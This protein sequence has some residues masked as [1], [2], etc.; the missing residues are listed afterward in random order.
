MKITAFSGL[1]IALACS[2]ASAA[3]WLVVASGRDDVLLVDRASLAR[4]GTRAEAWV[5][6][7]HESVVRSG[8]GARE[9]RS[10]KIQLVFDCRARTHGTARRIFMSGPLGGGKVV[11]AETAAS[12]TLHMVAAQTQLDNLLLE[13]ACSS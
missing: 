2:A 9:Y 1:I 5:L 4:S 6:R 10:Q 11:A 7:S 8:D 12:A 3:D 13:M